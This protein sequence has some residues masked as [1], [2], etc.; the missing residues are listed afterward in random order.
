MVAVHRRAHATED[1]VKLH[2]LHTSAIR[3]AAKQIGATDLVVT[4]NEVGFYVSC[5]YRGKEY[6]HE[7]MFDRIP[8]AA[9]VRVRDEHLSQVPDLILRLPQL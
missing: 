9:R 5:R 4:V 3:V 8:L 6:Q 7:L 2:E 1:L